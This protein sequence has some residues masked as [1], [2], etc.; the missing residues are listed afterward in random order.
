M[1]VKIESNGDWLGT[2]VID[3]DTGE[4]ILCTGVSWFHQAGEDPTASI[5]IAC[6]PG[7]VVGVAKVYCTELVQNICEY[8]S[9]MD[10]EAR[11]SPEDVV[12]AIRDRFEYEPIEMSKQP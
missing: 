9:Q 6:A 2:S 3:A 11:L 12:M 8:F 1:R 4:S 10:E 7:V 5:E